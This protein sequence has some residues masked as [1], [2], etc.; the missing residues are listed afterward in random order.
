MNNL[1]FGKR[2]GMQSYS[3]FPRIFR[4]MKITTALMLIGLTCAYAS[5][6]AQKVTLALKNAKL[7]DAF[8]EISKQTEFKFLYNDNL[9]KHADRKSVV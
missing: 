2:R 4:I 6:K 1:T 3:L 7:E 5:G 8:K 9:V